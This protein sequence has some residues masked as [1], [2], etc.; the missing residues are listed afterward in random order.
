MAAPV[1]VAVATGNDELCAK[2]TETYKQCREKARLEKAALFP[3]GVVRADLEVVDGF[4]FYAT[5]R[6]TGKSTGSTDTYVEIVP[7]TR[8]ARIAA[9]ADKSSAK[10]RSAPDINKFFEVLAHKEIN[11]ASIA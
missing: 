8:A 10:F 4:A 2:L 6:T 9:A 7:G 3:Q 11:A 5:I 1:N